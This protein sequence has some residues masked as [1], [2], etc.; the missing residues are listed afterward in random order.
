MS[1]YDLSKWRSLT[2]ALGIILLII[3]IEFF[4]R[5]YVFFW[6]PQIGLLQVNDMLCLLVAYIILAGGFGLITRTDWRKEI[7]DI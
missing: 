3:T 2:Q 5:H 1:I 6:F 7:P 4:F